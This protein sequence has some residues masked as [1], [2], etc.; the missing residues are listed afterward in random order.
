MIKSQDGRQRQTLTLN[1]RTILAKFRHKWYLTKN[2]DM[3]NTTQI[4]EAL[5]GGGGRVKY[6]TTVAQTGLNCDYVIMISSSTLSALTD[7]L[8]NNLLTSGQLGLAANAMPALPA[9]WILR[10]PYGRKIK[11]IT[12]SSGSAAA[13][14]F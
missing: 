6:F 4:D 12:L 9:F 11:N 5:I 7:D 13:Y 2:N 8:D 14:W 10:A 3:A 1:I